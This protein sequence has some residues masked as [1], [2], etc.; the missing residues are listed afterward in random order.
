MPKAFVVGMLL[1]GAP[2]N[3]RG[4]ASLLLDIAT[5]QVTAERKSVDDEDESDED[6]S[7]G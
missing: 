3:T 2:R 4:D 6:Q 1:K 5:K 7:E